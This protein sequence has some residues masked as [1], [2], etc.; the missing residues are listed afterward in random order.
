MK[1]Y[2]LT[3]L[4]TLFAAG[5][6]CAQM[7]DAAVVRYAKEGMQQGKSRQ[8]IGKELMLRGVTRDQIERLRDRYE[9]DETPQTTRIAP[10]VIDRERQVEPVGELSGSPVTA[11]G[12][13][14]AETAAPAPQ[15]PQ[16]PQGTQGTQQPQETIYGHSVFSSPA[17]TFEPNVNQ[18]TPADYRL[19]PGDEVIID[20]W[21]ANEDSVRRTI[22]P[23]GNIMVEQLGPVFL[24][25][26]TI[27]EAEQKIRRIFAR[28][29]A[30]V[31]GDEPE[32][33][34]GLTLGRI[35]TIQI[36]LMGEVTTPGTYRLSPFSTVFHALYK[37]GGITPIGT[38]RNIDV[39][40]GGKRLTTVDVYDYLFRGDLTGDIRLQEGD[41]IIVHPYDRLVAIDG[42]VKRPMRYE[43][44]Q[45]E[46]LA[47]LLAYAGGFTGDAYT[48]DVRLIRR[49]GR[50]RTIHTIDAASFERCPMED[51]D[52]VTVGATLERF[53]NMVEV[54]GAIYRPGLYELGT[55]IQSIGDL[56]RRADGVTEDAFRAR[57]LLYREQEDL[58][59]EMI[60]VNLGGI[61][62]GTTPDI[63]LRRNDILVIANIRELEEKG[64][65]TI[66]GEVMRPGSY[67]YAENTTI[68]DLI[69]RAGGLLDGASTAKVDVSRRLKDPRGTAPTRELSRIFT[70]A[71]K[72]GYVV[73]GNPDFVLEPYDIVDVRKSPAYQIQQQ[74]TLAGEVVFPGNYTLVRKTERI[75]DLVKRAGGITADAYLRGGRLLRRMNEEERAVREETLRMARQDSGSDSLSL[76]KLQV[77]DTYPVGIELDKALENPGSD[78]DMVL[79]EG[80]RL[81]VPEYVSTVKVAGEVMRPNTVLYKSNEGLKYYIDQ[82]GGY[83]SDAKRGRAYIVY[84]NGTIARTKR[85][86]RNRLEPGCE[87]IV[88]TKRARRR[89][90]LAE[91]L[92]ITTSAATLGTAAAA[93]ANSTK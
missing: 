70:F 29:Y 28:K 87:I 73:E 15:Q 5:L 59:L 65:L 45:N 42:N 53:A 62:D 32:S 61:L 36:N 54:R 92:G 58:T 82:A 33:E 25:G 11:E 10:A 57:A 84:M 20:I 56:V 90:S 3:T 86:G 37:A 1:K 78:Y 35:R 30:G 93:I 55:D 9:G 83:G 41:V 67:P 68:E 66:G 14:A 18:A 17:L 40:R 76:G 80:D 69:I 71:V 46:T 31:S 64:D 19:G 49:S 38:L 13:P 7:S 91:I 77:G 89:T 6:A 4:F 39:L 79:R 21:G 85:W 48:A 63:A 23:E 2:I 43:L 16:Q 34:I 47:A 88:P 27:A 12:T 74:V 52:A 60:A 22:T 26:L 8:Q 72:D 44:K 81:V 24:N 51:G 50:E 75:S